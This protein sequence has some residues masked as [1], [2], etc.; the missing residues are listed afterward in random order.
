MQRGERHK[1]SYIHHLSFRHFIFLPLPTSKDALPLNRSHRFLMPSCNSTSD[2]SITLQELKPISS[3]PYFPYLACFQNV[4]PLEAY[5]QHHFPRRALL[6]EERHLM[7][8]PVL[9]FSLQTI[10]H[11]PKYIFFSKALS[12]HTRYLRIFSNLN[13]I[14]LGMLNKDIT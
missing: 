6:S 13:L 2:P 10:D 7:L 12:L 8:R 9:L 4:S 14:I 1:G 5:P 3:S 11:F